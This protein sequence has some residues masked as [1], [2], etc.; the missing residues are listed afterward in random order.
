[1]LGG[2][3]SSLEHSLVLSILCPLASMVSHPPEPLGQGSW[4]T[5]LS[6]HMCLQCAPALTSARR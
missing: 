1:M 6:V 2:D 5:H 3:S 4:S